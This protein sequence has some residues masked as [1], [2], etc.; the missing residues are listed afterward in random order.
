MNRRPSLVLRTTR[1]LVGLI[2]IWCLGCSG[3]EPI[4]ESLALEPTTPAMND[5]SV[6]GPPA[7]VSKAIT[8]EHA[9]I[10]IATNIAV[11]P[12]DAGFDCCSS[13]C[14]HLV[15]IDC[16]SAVYM[17]FH[18]LQQMHELPGELVSISRAPLIPPPQL[19]V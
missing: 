6:T 7:G 12:D 4:V 8:S 10:E 1:A 15:F 9:A 17:P 2:T 18:T 19:T 11:D 14:C 16:V 13:G 3:Y 5:D